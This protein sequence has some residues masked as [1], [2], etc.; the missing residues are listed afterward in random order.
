MTHLRLL[1]LFCGA[2]GAGMGYHLAGFTDIVGVDIQQQSR[3]PFSF[4][5][6]DALDYLAA[7]GQEFD[8]IHASP[9]CQR[10]TKLVKQ[11]H[12][13]AQYPDLLPATLV[14]VQKSTRP[15]VVENV[16][17]ARHLMPSAV[18]LCGSMFGL[19]VQRHR[20][21][22]TSIL[23]LAGDCRHELQR[24]RFRSLD[25]R[26]TTL[27]SVVGVHGH[28]S[29]AGERRLREEAMG[30]NWMTPDEL[31]QAIPPAYTAW[32]GRQ[33]LGRLWRSQP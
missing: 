17:T 13:E 12:R 18:M 10:Y 27:A 30:I 22:S 3:Y 14:S 7:H 11:K 29:Y 20:Y 23:C 19:D 25:H 16:E 33:L 8:V 5:Q 15:Y 24:P 28:L 31:S 6:G 21:F 1:D 4:V 26:R 9:P 2:G 32:I